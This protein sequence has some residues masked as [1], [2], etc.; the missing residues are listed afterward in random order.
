MGKLLESLAKAQLEFEPIKKTGLNPFLKNSYATLDDIV[1]ATKVGLAN[2]GLS[3]VHRIEERKD[4]D[5]LVSEL[6]HFE[7]DDAIST[8]SCIDKYVK[9]NDKT[10]LIQT[11]GSILT[12][13]KRYHIS[14]LLNLCTDEDNDGNEAE[15]KKETPKTETKG[16]PEATKP[17]QADTTANEPQYKTADEYIARMNELNDATALA[18]WMTKHSGDINKLEN[19]DDRVRIREYHKERAMALSKAK[20]LKKDE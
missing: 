4:K 11:Y 20:D 10:S 9:A 6:W 18:K 1:N 13:L 14:L 12:Y 7:E 17:E 15:K 5:Y 8:Y 2:N 3:V 16:Q 19:T